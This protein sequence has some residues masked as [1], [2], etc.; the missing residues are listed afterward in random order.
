MKK[1]T[2]RDFIK[3]RRALIIITI[4]FFLYHIYIQYQVYELSNKLIGQEW[5]INY[6][7]KAQSHGSN[8]LSVEY[9]NKNNLMW[10]MQTNQNKSNDKRFAYNSTVDNRIT[11]ML[12]QLTKT[13]AIINKNINH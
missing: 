8:S 11:N 12:Y 1:I 7:I 2:G 6:L 5:K 4:L 3:I 9:E 13:V 10:E